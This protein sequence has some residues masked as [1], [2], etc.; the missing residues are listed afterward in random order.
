VSEENVE[1]VRRLNAVTNSGD[2]EAM[3][4]LFDPDVE[5][6]D[7]QHAPDLPEEVHGADAVMIALTHWT[8]SFED[9]GSEVYDYID[10]DPWVIADA[11]WRGKVKGTDVTV[12]VRQAD[13]L[14]V[15]DGK[16]VA[17]IT[18]FPDVAAALTAVG[19]EE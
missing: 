19:L 12:D 6:R 11:R 15:V 8:D 13:A 18:A 1:I 17:V 9:L 14:K 4:E 3:L 10:A 2:R 5:F 16:V 7:L